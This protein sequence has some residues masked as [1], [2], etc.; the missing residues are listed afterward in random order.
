MQSKLLG[1][2]PKQ[3]TLKA[4]A[5]PAILKYKVFSIVKH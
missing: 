1:Y 3:K 4:E 5:L 2:E